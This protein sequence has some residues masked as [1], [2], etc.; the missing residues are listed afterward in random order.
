MAEQSY[1]RTDR[2]DGAAGT[3]K[4]A[5]GS[6]ETSA[7]G[8][9]PS[10]DDLKQKVVSTVAS[11]ADHQKNRAADG[12]GGIADVARQTGDDLRG[13]N[14]MLASWVNAASDQ[15]RHMA[16]RLRDRPAAELADDLTRFAR[17]RP[18][19]FLGGAFLLGLGVARLL[20]A[21][22]QSS[23]PSPDGNG[24]GEPRRASAYSAP[25]LGGSA[26]GDGRPPEVWAPGGGPY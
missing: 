26:P 18:A 24:H 6:T 3:A 4:P 13:Q 8:G 21:S 7:G 17:E 20:R 11:A 10:M 16:E 19:V 1:T 2:G 15:L 14:E 5:T 25:G 9:T 23:W 12:I 22:P